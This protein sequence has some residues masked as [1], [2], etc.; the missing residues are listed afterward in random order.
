MRV[1]GTRSTGTI[2]SP[3]HD[4][5]GGLPGHVASM[6][7]STSGSYSCPGPACLVRLQPALLLA[8]ASGSRCLWPAR[9]VLLP[10]MLWS[11]LARLSRR[12]ATCRMLG[13]L[14]PAQ[15]PWGPCGAQGPKRRHRRAGLVGSESAQ[16]SWSAVT[17]NLN[18]PDGLVTPLHRYPGVAALSQSE[19]DLDWRAQ[20]GMLVPAQLLPS[21]LSSAN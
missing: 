6:P 18:R 4:S 13:A 2:P 8:G 5:G 20:I 10:T 17:C 1:A 16:P 9:L 3:I 19:S 12:M 15:C 7:I 14:S 11:D 21:Q